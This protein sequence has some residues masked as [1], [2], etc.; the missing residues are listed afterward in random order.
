MSRQDPPPRV[1]D[2]APVIV[3]GIIGRQLTYWSGNVNHC[4]GCGR[5][6]WIIGRFSAECAFCRT[7][8]ALE[9]SGML[10]VGTFNRNHH[11]VA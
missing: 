1:P 3:A 4:P 8:L 2:H 9:H 11:H 7:A 10:G 5:T 6:N